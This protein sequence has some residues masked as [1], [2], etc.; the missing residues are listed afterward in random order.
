MRGEPISD[1]LISIFDPD[2]RPIRKGKL[3]KRNEF[4]CVAQICEVTEKTKTGARGLKIAAA[5]SRLGNPTEDTL[6]P[7]TAAELERLGLSPREVALDCGFNVGPSSQTLDPFAPERAFI[8][9]CQ[10][11]GSKRTQRRLVRYPTGAEGRIS[12]L[13]R[14]YGMRRTRVKGHDGM[15]T[16][17]GWSILAHNLDTLTIRSR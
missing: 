12:H 14:G 11:P 17:T 8:A 2:A 13:K 1:R 16:W 10:H 6:L 3:G 15:Q 9:G 4:G 5:S 7:E